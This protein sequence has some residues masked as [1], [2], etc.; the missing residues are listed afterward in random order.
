MDEGAEHPAEYNRF[1]QPMFP[2]PSY[3]SIDI[4]S[5]L[6]L[7]KPFHAAQ[8]RTPNSHG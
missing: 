5:R 8:L 7:P 4:L 3:Y 6:I 2:V 1:G